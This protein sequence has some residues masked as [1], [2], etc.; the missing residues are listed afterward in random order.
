MNILNPIIITPVSNVNT[1]IN[2]SSWCVN[3]IIADIVNII[4]NIQKQTAQYSVMFPIED[5]Y[6]VQL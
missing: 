6:Q 4:P 1:D 3:I 2:Q 5:I